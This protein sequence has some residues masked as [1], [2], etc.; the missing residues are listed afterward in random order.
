MTAIKPSTVPASP[1]QSC[2]QMFR[3]TKITKSTP[4]VASSHD[5]C[6]QGVLA[7]CGTNRTVSPALSHSQNLAEISL[8][9]QPIAAL[10]REWLR[11]ISAIA[12]LSRSATPEPG[13][14]VSHVVIQS[15]PQR[16]KWWLLGGVCGVVL[17]AGLLIVGLFIVDAASTSSVR[18]QNES[19]E[20]LRLSGCSIDDALD[21]TP[22]DA[23]SVDV[24]A[25]G[26]EGCSVF[27]RDGSRYLGCLTLP[28]PHAGLVLIRQSLKPDITIQLCEKI[29]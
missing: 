21:L 15:R 10:L 5:C 8:G 29:R 18:V 25:G 1:S 13:L 20:P 16:L 9:E 2:A 14:T 11:G 23:G 26:K 24:I 3:T 19:A 22:G 6:H 28:T 7:D 12:C 4:R 17:L 27:D